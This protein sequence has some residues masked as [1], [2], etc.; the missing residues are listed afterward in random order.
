MLY[1]QD[2]EITRENLITKEVVQYY[3]SS[4][5]LLSKEGAHKPGC[6]N[7]I[8]YFQQEAVFHSSRNPKVEGKV[9]NSNNHKRF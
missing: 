6:I 1:K 2:Y 8:D 3:I 5:C 4:H 7:I 9:T